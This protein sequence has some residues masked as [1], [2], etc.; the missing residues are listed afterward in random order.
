MAMVF[1]KETV[2]GVGFG[3]AHGIMQK[4]GVIFFAEKHGSQ[5]QVNF[6]GNVLSRI[7]SNIAG[8]KT[9]GNA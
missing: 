5:S 2:Y 9:Q 1:I 4:I 8:L 7:F 6:A 3:F